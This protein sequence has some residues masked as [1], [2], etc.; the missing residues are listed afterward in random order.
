M[1]YRG[2]PNVYECKLM[3]DNPTN[4][5]MNNCMHKPSSKAMNNSMNESMHISRKRVIYY[6]ASA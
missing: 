4:K 2:S 1:A 6:A 5:S 3:I